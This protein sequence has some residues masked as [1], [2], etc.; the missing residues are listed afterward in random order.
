LIDHIPIHHICYTKRRYQTFFFSH[1]LFASACS[2]I[3]PAAIPRHHQFALARP[4]KG[5]APYVPPPALPPKAILAAA[6]AAAG[7]GGIR[8]LFVFNTQFLT[9]HTPISITLFL[10]HCVIWI[11]FL[12]S[13]IRYLFLIHVWRIMLVHCASCT[14]VIYHVHLNQRGSAD[15][16][17]GG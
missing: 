1:V 16:G 17:G 8:T 2:T 5:P 4:V 14:H 3:Q 10:H 12:V 9:F 6:K 15:V 7:F 13:P 11:M